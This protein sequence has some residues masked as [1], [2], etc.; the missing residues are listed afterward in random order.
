MQNTCA[1][2][3][4]K[5]HRCAPRIRAF[6]SKTYAAGPVSA[7][8]GDRSSRSRSG[9]STHAHAPALPRADRARARRTSGAL[10]P[11]P[12]QVS[13]VAKSRP[14]ETAMS[15]SCALMHLG[16]AGSE[17]GLIPS[18]GLFTLVG[19][20]AVAPMHL[21]SR[22]DMLQHDWFPGIPELDYEGWR[23]ALRPHFGRY[24]PV[25]TERK[26]FTGRARP[27]NLWGLV[28]MD[29]SCNAH[30]VERTE[31]D[32]RHD[33]VDHYFALFQVAG[34]STIIQ[35]DQVVQLDE[36]DA[37]LVDS[38][39]PGRHVS[40]EGCGRWISLQ[41]PRRSLVSHLGFDPR[42]GVL[43]RG[44]TAAGRAL[45]DLVR[46]GS[47]QPIPTRSWRSTISSVPYWRGPVQCPSR[48]MRTS[49]SSSSATS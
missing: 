29:L 37:A 3:G 8:A 2:L 33:G 18:T 1:K 21:K 36:G 11:C 48:L 30:R 14:C 6:A 12:L 20:L 22:D 27:R 41:L 43:R 49:C 4:G 46:Q 32:V 40:D 47:H 24:D 17:L 15:Y 16:K 10:G 38:A 7:G 25:V 44:G 19:G 5:N 26:A 23:D 35:N 42:D 34:A 45:F 31:R 39:Q 28:A 9:V 13:I